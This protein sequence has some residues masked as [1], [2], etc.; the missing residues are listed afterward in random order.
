MS[1]LAL[2]LYRSVTRYVAARAVGGRIPGT[3]AGPVAPLRLVN[4]AAPELPAPGW[5]RVRPLLSGICGSDLATLSGQSSLYFSPLVSMPFVPGHEVVGEL[6]DDVVGQGGNG[7]GPS[8]PPPLRAGQRVV[9]DPVLSCAT[10][11]LAPCAGCRDGV[12]SRCD[13]VTVGHIAPGLQTGYCADTGGGW[14][15]QLIAHATQLHAVPDHLPDAHAVLVEPLAC[16]VHTVRRAR[17]EPGQSVLVVG[18]GTVGLLTLFALRA[19][20]QAGDVTV[21]AKHASQSALAW[22]LDAT[23]VVP[24]QRAPKALRRA[25]R[26]FLLSPERGGDFLLGGADVAFECSGSRSGLDLALRTVR[27]AGK[28]V[29]SGLPGPGPDLTPLWYREL[30]LVGAYASGT[31]HDEGG[32]SEHDFDTAIRLAGRAPLEGVVGATYPLARWRDA[33]DHAFGAGRLG[34]LKVA[35][36]PTID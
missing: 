4:R 19:L 34:T 31:H 25:T 11:G 28:V 35:F 13:R 9:L 8:S 3:L 30:E 15:R 10:R 27:A 21:V 14:G 22:E 32:G 33:L 16:A 1:V 17:I 12:T 29:L 20:T 24:P 5:V 26:A 7:S 36:D 6:L 18:A 23:D 2:E